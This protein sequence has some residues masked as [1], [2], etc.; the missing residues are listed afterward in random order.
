MGL[1]TEIAV[2]STTVSLTTA[3]SGRT[4]TVTSTI[5]TVGTSDILLPAITTGTIG[6]LLVVVARTSVGIGFTSV[7]DRCGCARVGIGSHATIST[8]GVGGPGSILQSLLNTSIDVGLGSRARAG[9]LIE[10][11][12]FA[13]GW[14]VFATEV[15]ATGGAAVATCT[16]LVTMTNIAVLILVDIGIV[17]CGQVMT[18]TPGG[19][20]AAAVVLVVVA[21]PTV[22]VVVG[23]REQEARSVTAIT[24]A[25]VPC[26]RCIA[27]DQT[28]TGLTRVE[29]QHCDGGTFSV[30]LAVEG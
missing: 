28:F 11:F 16:T 24:T 23:Q 4:L 15:V 26:Y 6:T 14:V 22:L 7:T 9:C 30:T 21:V 1:T 12:H 19:A 29:L 18:T 25:V 2:V 27:T 3:A 10:D 5:T 20:I 8:T 13:D 17:T